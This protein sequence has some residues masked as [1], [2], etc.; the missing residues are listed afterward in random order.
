MQRARGFFHNKSI[1]LTSYLCIL[2]R[3]ALTDTC[4]QQANKWKPDQMQYN[5]PNAFHGNN[6]L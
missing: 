6:V 1:R 3:K 4:A 5:S 2:L